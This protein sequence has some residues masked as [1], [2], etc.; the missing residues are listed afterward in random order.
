MAVIVTETERHDGKIL[1]LSSVA[2]PPYRVFVNFAE[3][4]IE[5]GEWAGDEATI[6]RRRVSCKLFYWVPATGK[7]RRGSEIACRAFRLVL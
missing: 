6:P 7:E 2:D 5:G 4:I 1:V 3:R